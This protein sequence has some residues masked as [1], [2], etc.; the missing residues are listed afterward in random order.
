MGTR[1]HLSPL[2]L[3]WRARAGP[4]PSVP[5]RG[6]GWDVSIAASVVYDLG[7]EPSLALGVLTAIIA[8]IRACGTE[9]TPSPCRPG[10][11]E[12][13]NGVQPVT[14]NQ[15]PATS[16]LI[17]AMQRVPRSSW[18]GGLGHCRKVRARS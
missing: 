17:R 12:G 6:A 7:R 2:D 16:S 10:T 13:E 18:V 3:F 14:R 8:Q 9:E 4:R 15:E 11:T 1:F 5:P